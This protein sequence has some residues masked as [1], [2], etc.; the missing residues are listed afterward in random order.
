MNDT[1]E[2]K[3]WLHYTQVETWQFSAI[4]GSSTHKNLSPRASIPLSACASS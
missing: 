3:D 2:P 4:N 1:G